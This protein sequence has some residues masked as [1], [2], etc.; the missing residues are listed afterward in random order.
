MESQLAPL[1]EFL[2]EIIRPIVNS[3]VQ[4]AMPKPSEKKAT[5]DLH[6]RRSM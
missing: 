2:T 6:S 1:K 4:E 3:A 5:P